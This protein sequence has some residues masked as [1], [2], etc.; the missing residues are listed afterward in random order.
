[1]IV[2]CNGKR[3]EFEANGRTLAD[4]R[5]FV[6]EQF[7]IAPEKQKLV[8][9]GK[10]YK[11]TDEANLPDVKKALVLATTQENVEIAEKARA[12]GIRDREKRAY[13]LTHRGLAY[14]AREEPLEYT[15][16]GVEALKYGDHERAQRY[17]E[18][19]RDDRAV[20]ALMKKYKLNVGRLT[21]LDPLTNTDF[22]GGGTIEARKLGLNVGQG[23]EIRL[24]IRTDDY[25][26]FRSYR[27][28]KMVLCH[29]LAHN[30]HGD[31]DA[32]FWR[33]CKLYEREIEHLDPFGGQGHRLM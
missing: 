9:G 24:R 13:Q 10:S 17:L 18:R 21:E 5:K 3:E 31:H 16:G 1:M 6:L 4:L 28:T 32:N 33:L 8:L 14:K 22:G 29:E 15:F 25:E 23:L 19:I 2:A 27:D 7:G 12:E 30:S 11:Y 26:G 20:Q